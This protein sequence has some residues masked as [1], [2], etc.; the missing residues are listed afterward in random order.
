MGEGARWHLDGGTA[1][2]LALETTCGRL[3]YHTWCVSALGTV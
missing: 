1:E 3:S 2:A